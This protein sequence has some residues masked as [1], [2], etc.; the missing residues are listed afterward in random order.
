MALG[1]STGAVAGEVSAAIAAWASRS[2]SVNAQQLVRAVV[3]RAAP[4]TPARAKALLFAAAKLAGFG[5]QVGLGLSAEV[6]LHP[7]VIERFVV[8]GCGTVSPATRRTLRTNLRALARAGEPYPE[9]SP[10][11]LPRERAKQ[12]Y[13]DAEIAGYLALAAA[14][15]TVARRMRSSALVCLGAGAGLIGSELRHLTGSDVAWRS[16]GLLV[17]VSGQ[18]ARAVPVLARFGEPLRA[19]AQF[20]GE[21][22]LV[23]GAA[24]ARRNLSDA[25]TAALCQ[26]AG[27]PRLEAGRLR[28][29]WLCECAEL[30][31]LHAFMHAAGVRCSQRLGDLIDY[32]PDAEEHAAVA[33]LGAGSR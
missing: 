23:G 9:P 3:A 29:S 33:L 28:A 17:A 26:D 10:V 27:L 19:A 21:G 8:Q 7:S 20:A 25:L 16:G 2:L 32:L 24:P 6:L 30:I 14:Q 22:Y 5:E 15:A 1:V 4:A 31:G 11:A 13:S 12:P 18:R